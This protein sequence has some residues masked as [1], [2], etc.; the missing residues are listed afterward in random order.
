[1]G[2]GPAEVQKPNVI[3]I[4]TDDQGYGDLGAH[5]HPY[6]QTP[7]LDHLHDNSIRLTNFHVAP[8]CTPSRSQL[9]TGIDALHNGAYSAHGQHHLLDTSFYTLAEAFQDNGYATALYGKWHL[10]GNAV[11]YRPHE[12]GFDEAVHFLRGGHFSHPNYWNSDCFDDWYYHN[13]RPE[14]YA[15]YATD[16]WFDLG[17]Q[18]VQQQQAAQRPFFLYLPLNAPHLP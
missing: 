7:Q 1:M 9:L 5:G 18:F 17:K 15:G 14:Q 11:G 3:L 2:P 12:R 8:A 6:L 13:G 10:G 4:V 16:I